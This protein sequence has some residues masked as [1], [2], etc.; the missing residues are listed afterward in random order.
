M[1]VK[2]WR[3]EA[4]SEGKR[5][6]EMGQLMKLREVRVERDLRAVRDRATSSEQLE[7]VREMRWRKGVEESQ[8]VVEGREWEEQGS[9]EVGMLSDW[10]ALSCFGSRVE[11]ETGEEGVGVVADG[12]DGEGETAAALLVGERKRRRRRRREGSGAIVGIVMED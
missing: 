8:V 10:S 3:L 6:G 9:L 12:G 11:E 7:S 2:E 1:Q 4:R 5:M